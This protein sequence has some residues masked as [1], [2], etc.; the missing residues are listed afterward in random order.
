MKK[1]LPKLLNIDGVRAL[2]QAGAVSHV[3][4]IASD[5]GLCVELNQIFKVTNRAKEIRYFAKAETVFSW[6]KGM[7]INQINEVDLSRWVI[8]K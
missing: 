5:D 8:E 3:K 4:V 2:A 6:L 7:G 1:P